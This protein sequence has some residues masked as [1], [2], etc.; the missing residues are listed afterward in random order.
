MRLLIAH[1]LQPVL[2]PPQEVI[3]LGQDVGVGARDEAAFGE[4]AERLDCAARPK[5]RTP[6]AHD[7]LL[8][9]GEELDVADAA[10]AELDV[11][12]LHRD[13]AMPLMRVHPP[14]HGVDVG[15]CG[16]VEIFAPDEGCQL[17]QELLAGRLVARGDARL[18]QRR[19]LPVLAEALVIGE[20]CVGRERD[21]RRA[22]IGP[23]P[24][25]GAEHITVGGVL[26]Q[27]AYEL[28]RQ[29]HEEGG[30]LDVRREPR[31]GR[32]VKD[33]KVDV[34]RIVELHRPELAHGD[35]EIA[36]RLRHAVACRHLPG[37]TRLAEQ[38]IGGRF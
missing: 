34:A 18:D 11:V 28:P 25:I 10:A 38:K 13:G 26:L 36:A 32:V 2:D 29:L 33:H 1:H 14:F 17:A 24:E 4:P 15:D 20:A 21:L 5:L 30:R 31:A 7:E 3:G 12:P 22:W 19:A 27:Q 23:E 8:G 35:D 37:L 16:V 6:A 9:L